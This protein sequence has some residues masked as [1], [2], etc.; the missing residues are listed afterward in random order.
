MR[1]ITVLLLLVTAGLVASA[2]AQEE[3]EETRKLVCVASS[4]VGGLT[5]LMQF[6]P[7]LPKTLDAA[8]FIENTNSYGRGAGKIPDTI[9][10]LIQ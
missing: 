7:S 10:K 9:N 5:S 2:A 1:N 3:E 6:I 8:V 4:T